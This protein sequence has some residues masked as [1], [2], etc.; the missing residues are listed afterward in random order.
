M[1]II[2]RFLAAAALLALAAPALAQSAAEQAFGR[3][4]A[5][6]QA[7][8]AKLAG[9]Y[10]ALDANWSATL[11]G[12][13]LLLGLDAPA[14]AADPAQAAL[15]FAKDHAALWGVSAADLHVVGAIASRAGHS[16][17]LGLAVAVGVA[18]APLLDRRLTVT[19]APDGLRVRSVASDLLP[20]PALRAASVPAEV[21]RERALRFVGLCEDARAAPCVALLR[22]TTARL[23][24]LADVAGAAPVWVVDVQPGGPLDR[25]SV[26]VDAMGGAA[27]RQVPVAVD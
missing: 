23:A 27:L 8:V 3:Q 22:A 10:R 21:A 14:R 26:L 2:H 1:R 9:Q 25:R 15:L 5:R 4:R 7:L 24:V 18:A 20:V 13:A 11:P 6:S 17:H 16:V 12:P 19:L